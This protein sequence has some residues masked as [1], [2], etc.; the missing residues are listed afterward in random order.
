MTANEVHD[1]IDFVYYA[2]AN[3]TPVSAKTLGYNASDGSTDIAIQPYPSDHRS[4]V[5]NFNVPTCS[6]FGDLS[7]NCSLGVEDWQQFRAGQLANMTGLTHS[8]A[9]ANGDLNGDFRNNH[10]DFLLF[11]SAYDIAHGAGAFLSMLSAVPEPS[12][13]VLSFLLGAT[14]LLVGRRRRSAG[15]AC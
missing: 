14:G 9:Y 4:V 6:I 3:V 5:V 1:R 11:K 7:G 10:A 8:Q 15:R 2:G 12:T 13:G